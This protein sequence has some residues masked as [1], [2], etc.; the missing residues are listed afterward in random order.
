M[1]NSLDIAKSRR[2]FRRGADWHTVAEF[3]LAVLSGAV[4]GV[5]LVLLAAGLWWE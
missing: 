4:L 2:V 3:T 1:T 5:G